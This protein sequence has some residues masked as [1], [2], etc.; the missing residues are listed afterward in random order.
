VSATGDLLIPHRAH[1]EVLEVGCPTC[2]QDLVH[3]ENTKGFNLPE[4]STCMELCHD[5]EKSTAE[6]IK[7]HTRKQVPDDHLEEDWLL[8]HSEMIDTVDC[9][10][11]H[12]WSPDYC[13]DCHSE[14]PE[15]HSVGNWK[16]LH[17]YP[18]VERG[19]QGCMTCHDEEKCL[20]C[21]D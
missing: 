7:C 4:M 18:A 13:A 9:G 17:Q 1:V 21:H 5:G 2:H 11:C 14:L 3:S 12:A 10:E 20:E 8:V 19:E 15:S 6:C 16:D